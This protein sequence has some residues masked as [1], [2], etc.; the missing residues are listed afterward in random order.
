MGEEVGTGK[1]GG[2]EREGRRWR[3][4]QKELE[5]GKEDWKC[6]KGGPNERYGERERNMG[7]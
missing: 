5:R 2:G 3:E 4:G 7:G 1:E 6:T